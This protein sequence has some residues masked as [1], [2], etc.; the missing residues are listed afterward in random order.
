MISP[1][2]QDELHTVHYPSFFPFPWRK[3][4]TCNSNFAIHKNKLTILC[5]CCWRCFVSHQRSFFW[6]KEKWHSKLW[7]SSEVL[8][9][10]RIKTSSVTETKSICLVFFLSSGFTVPWVII[11]SDFTWITRITVLFVELNCHSQKKNKT[12]DRSRHVPALQCHFHLHL[13]LTA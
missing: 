10:M 6:S 13:F 5:F 9:W 12:F 1:C 8:R 2:T 11:Y 4:R 3:K 7:D